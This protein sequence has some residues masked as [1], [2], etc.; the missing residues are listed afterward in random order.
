M[1]AL[2]QCRL[3]GMNGEASDAVTQSARVRER[4]RERESE[5]ASRTQAHILGH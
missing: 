5:R 3:E 1:C 2:G 4:M